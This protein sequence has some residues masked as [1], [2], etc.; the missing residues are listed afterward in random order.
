MHKL[1]MCSKN[2]DLK[3]GKVYHGLETGPHREPRPEQS[4]VVLRKATKEE[5]LDCMVSFG[6]ERVWEEMICEINGPWYYY[7]IQ[8]D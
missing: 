3:T 5:Y 2:S 1:I 6:S 7:E 8:T 4:Y